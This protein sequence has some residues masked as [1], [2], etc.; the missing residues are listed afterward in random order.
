MIFSEK[1]FSIRGILLKNPPLF[2]NPPPYCV[3]IGIK[4]GILKYRGFRYGIWPPEAENF[5][6]FRLCLQGKCIILGI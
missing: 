2:K 6:D 3:Q 4:G 1:A 5:G